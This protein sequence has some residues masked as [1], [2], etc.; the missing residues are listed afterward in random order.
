MSK[1]DSK[2]SFQSYDDIVGLVPG[3]T[4]VPSEVASVYLTN[5]GSPDLEP[6]FVD[7]YVEAQGGVKRLLGAG[8]DDDVCSQF[9][10]QL[11]CC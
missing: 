11:G 2:T 9:W 10:L 5:F 7:A 8:D 4:S 6:A 1:K 3:P